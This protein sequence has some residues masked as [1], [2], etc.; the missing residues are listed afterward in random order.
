MIFMDE[1]E[2][3]HQKA[4][5]T[6]TDDNFQVQLGCHFEEIGEMVVELDGR[7][8]ATELALK[9]VFSAVEDLAI[10]LKGGVFKVDIYDRVGLLDS[11]VDQVVTSIGTGYCAKMKMTKGLNEVNRSNWSKFDTMGNPVFDENGKIKKGDNY[12]PPNLEKYV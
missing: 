11:L 9:R 3:W 4:R 12:S 5:P 6:P 2:A 10:G 8:P 1:I 7:D